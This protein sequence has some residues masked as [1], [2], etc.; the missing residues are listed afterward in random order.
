MN[1][2]C[3]RSE[4]LAPLPLADLIPVGAGHAISKG[5]LCALLGVDDRTLRHMVQRER[6][7]GV[8]ILSSVERAG[9]YK[10]ENSEE[11]IRFVKSMRS[12]AAETLAVADAVENALM[13]EAGQIKI[14]GG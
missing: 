8:Q 9:Y 14:G 13:T 6:K 4:R 11:T 7:A 1:N 2:D 3:T 12:R 10:P 5:E